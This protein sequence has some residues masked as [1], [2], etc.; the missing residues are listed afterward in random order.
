MEESKGVE[1]T[2]QLLEEIAEILKSILS[3]GQRQTQNQPQ[4]P[5]QT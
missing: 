4:P 3:L 2:N 1:K 5:R